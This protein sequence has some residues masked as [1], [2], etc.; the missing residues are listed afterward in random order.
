MHDIS[1]IIVDILIS[2]FW[3]GA[4]NSYFWNA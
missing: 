2:Q 1:I 4:A 3:L